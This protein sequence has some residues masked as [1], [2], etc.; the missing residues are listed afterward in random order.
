MEVAGAQNAVTPTPQ[1]LPMDRVR[2]PSTGEPGAEDL[3][4]LSLAG[5]GTVALVLGRG[6][7]RRLLVH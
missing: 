5:V 1:P 2:I 6:W 4:G 3:I 7:L